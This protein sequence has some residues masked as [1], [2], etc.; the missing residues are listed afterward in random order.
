[1]I[2]PVEFEGM[3]LPE[4]CQFKFAANALLVFQIPP[5][6]APTKSTQLSSP[7]FGEMATEV[8][9]PELYVAR[10]VYVAVGATRG[11]V[12]PIPDHA[13][14]VPEANCARD[15]NALY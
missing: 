2:V 15:R 14:P 9:L 3:P 4:G 5:P 12:G 11:S 6:A 8:T 13:F 10:P 1:M 7:H